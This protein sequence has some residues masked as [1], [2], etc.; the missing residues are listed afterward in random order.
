M[1][2]NLQFTHGTQRDFAK[3]ILAIL[4]IIIVRTHFSHA[5]DTINTLCI[6]ICEEKFNAID[7]NLKT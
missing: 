5:F 1:A 4:I 2:I 6:Y 7:H 3:E